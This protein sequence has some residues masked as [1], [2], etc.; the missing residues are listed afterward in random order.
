M[1]WNALHATIPYLAVQTIEV[2]EQIKV[3]EKFAGPL[4]LGVLDASIFLNLIV[5]L[6]LIPPPGSFWDA[7][8]AGYSEAMPD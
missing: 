6:P 8:S 4:A 7:N 5:P 3:L 1:L 2:L